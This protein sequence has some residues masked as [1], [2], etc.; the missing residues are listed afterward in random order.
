MVQSRAQ[1]RDDILAMLKAAAV[2]PATA[3]FVIYDDTKK[4]K[5]SSGT[6]L[7]AS[8]KHGRGS[9][10]TLGPNALHTQSGI[11][12]VQIFTEAGGGLSDNDAIAKIIEDAYR[13]KTS[14]NGVVF[15]DIVTKEVGQDGIWF[16]SNVEVEFEYDL[17]GA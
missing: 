8:I 10:A 12:F 15:R 9:R 13:G 6:W 14:Q 3:L 2:Y 17:V 11:L 16:Q 7:R 1:A 5:P 4:D